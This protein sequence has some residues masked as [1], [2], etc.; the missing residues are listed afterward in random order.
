MVKRGPRGGMDLAVVTN[1][2]LGASNCEP[3]EG[4]DAVVSRSEALSLPADES[5]EGRQEMDMLAGN[6]KGYGYPF[7][8]IVHAI[9][10]EWDSLGLTGWVQIPFLRIRI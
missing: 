8:G 2:S 7:G 5:D 10:G 6:V 4:V 1:G 9:I 3:E